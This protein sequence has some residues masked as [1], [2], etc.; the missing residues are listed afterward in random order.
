MHL[1]PWPSPRCCSRDR[2][3]QSLPGSTKYGIS[4]QLFSPVFFQPTKPDRCVRDDLHY[5]LVCKI[6]PF[7]SYIYQGI[8]TNIYRIVMNVGIE[9]QSAYVRCSS[10]RSTKHHTYPLFPPYVGVIQ[11]PRYLSFQY[12]FI[13][14]RN[15]CQYL[16]YRPL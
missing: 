3:F 2:C 13:I 5:E 12:R 11:A 7:I 14:K 9:Y 1:C 8:Y 6:R 10:G 16:L 15:H 4:L